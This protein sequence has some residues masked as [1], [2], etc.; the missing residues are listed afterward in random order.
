M[1]QPKPVPL[2]PRPLAFVVALA[3]STFA[4]AQPS[5]LGAILSSTGP[6]AVEGRPQVAVLEAV[7]AEWSERAPAFVDA[8]EIDLRDDVSDPLRAERLARE[9]IDGGAHLLICCS[10]DAAVRRVA[11]LAEERG[12]LLLSP[13]PPSAVEGSWEVALGA[14]DRTL[15]RSVIRHA[16]AAE[17]R[18]LGLM[19]LDTPF[20]DAAEGVLEAELALAGMELRGVA[21]HDGGERPLTPD[22]LWVATRQPSAVVVWSLADD[23]AAAID[24]LRRRGYAG[25]IYLRPSVTTGEEQPPPDGVLLPVPPFRVAAP[26]D[27]APAAAEVARFGRTVAGR[28]GEA[29]LTP[30][31]A[32]TYDLVTLA[33]RA[34]EQVAVYGVAPADT[35]RFRV[36]LRDAAIGLPTLHGAAGSY[37]VIDGRVEAALPEGLPVAEYVEGRYVHAPGR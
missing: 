2:R 7:L 37:D 5:H 17:R 12:V 18:M 8:I 30:G 23:S 21:R 19:T 22:A 29:Y 11:P 14:S 27:D 24:A 28:L 20:G 36:A 10:S 25:P 15:L 31:A 16:F 4:T 6:F 9:L 1:I 32:R 33:L 35:G 3:L 13:R 26:T 34:L